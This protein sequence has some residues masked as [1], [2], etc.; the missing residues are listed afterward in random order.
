MADIKIKKISEKTKWEIDDIFIHA[1]RGTIK[2][3]FIIAGIYWALDIIK[4]NQ[5]KLIN[6]HKVLLIIVIFLVTVVVSRIAVGFVNLYSRRA[7]GV[8]T[9]TSMFT[10][11]TRFL[12]YIIGILI[13]LQSLGISITP[14]LTALG[15]GGLAV[16]LALQD[17]LSNLFAGMHVIASSQ[18][19]P[20]HYIKL[21]STEEGFVT[22]ITWR[23]TTIRSLQNNTVIV[24]NSKLASAIVTNYNTPDEEIPV[25]VEIGVSYD[26]DLEIVER[27]TIET[28]REVMKEINGCVPD[29]EPS[30]R[31]YKFDDSTINFTITIRAKKFV[32]QYAIKHDLIKRLHKRYRQEGIDIPYPARTVYM[33]D[34]Q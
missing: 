5:E 31:Y 13:I 32:D 28:A 4:I 24:P 6:I 7:G 23:Y 17:T 10:N 30:L 19:K 21:S 14:I 27:I 12:V 25:S 16:A 29:Y 11:M 9:S 3:I 33:K 15:V 8:F 20:G 22:D 26:S 34:R 2:L 1:F 18:I